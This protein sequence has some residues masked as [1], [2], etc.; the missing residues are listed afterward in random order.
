[1][2]LLFKHLAQEHHN[3]MEWLKEREHHSILNV[4]RA[5]GFQGDL[6]TSFW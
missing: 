4:A 6:P 1:M 3:K 2:K 5:L